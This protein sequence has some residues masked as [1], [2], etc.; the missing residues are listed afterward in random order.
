MD[1]KTKARPATVFISVV[2]LAAAIATLFLHFGEP[3]PAAL[4]AP[5]TSAQAEA[6]NERRPPE[7]PDPTAGPIGKPR[8]TAAP[9]DDEVHGG[10]GGEFDQGPSVLDQI[11]ALHKM[12]AQADVSAFL[13]RN[14]ELAARHLDRYCE[15]SRKLARKDLFPESRRQRE[16]AGYLDGKIDWEPSPST[17]RIQGSLHL[18][19]PLADALKT[20]GKNWPDAIGDAELAGL[21]FSW[22]RDLLAYDTWSV[23][24][25]GP[26]ST[27]Q[28]NDVFGAPLPSYGLYSGWM[29]LRFAKALR[30]GDLAD[31]AAEV[32]HLGELLH[33]QGVL[34]GEMFAVESLRI[35]RAAFDAAARRGKAVAG[36][37][38]PESDQIEAW[39]RLARVSN[40]FFLPGVDPKVMARALECAPAPC[41]A[42]TE[43]AWIHS[44][45][46][47]LAPAGSSADFWRLTEGQPSC[48]P[49]VLARARATTP[50]QATEA[51]GSLDDAQ[52]LEK[53][54]EPKRPSGP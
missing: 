22:M 13:Q 6:V 35:E 3:P 23:T 44:A 46:G 15:E 49:G 20:A 10:F 14:A 42:L 47:D 37:S 18:A 24:A 28:S 27:Y 38:P 41:S 30:D 25:A 34:I 31:A 1:D 29:K 11:S 51:A 5:A 19:Q 26:L 36:W 33:S 7:K 32:R 39:R 17:P 4:P 48:E 54:F 12:S 43:A 45:L 40:H 9:A 16:A 53:T 8:A 2:V 52:M 50:M 21:D